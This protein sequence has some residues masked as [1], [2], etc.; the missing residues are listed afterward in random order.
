MP[1]GK[2]SGGEALYSVV[3]NFL[4]L[5]GTSEH[6]LIE[7]SAD[8]TRTAIAVLYYR[9]ILVDGRIRNEELHHYRVILSESLSVSEDELML[10]EKT[11]LDQIRNERSLF[12]FTVIVKKLPEDKRREILEHMHQI[13]ISDRE[14]HE[15]EINLVE[16]TAELLEI[17]DWQD[18]A[19]R[20]KN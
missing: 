5:L 10:F 14:L 17:E 13:S 12:P 9:V 20:T 3:K 15:F 8:D 2:Q 19:S 16:R 7:F 1:L 4:D 18:I 11:V 6:E